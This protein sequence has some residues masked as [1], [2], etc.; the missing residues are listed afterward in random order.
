M[1]IHHPKASDPRRLQVG[2]LG[3]RRVDFVAASTTLVKPLAPWAAAFLVL[4]LVAP[5]PVAYGQPESGP[6][7]TTATR[8][9][10]GLERYLGGFP[11]GIRG[12]QPRIP[13]E[14]LRRLPLRADL[15]VGGF[16]ESIFTTVPDPLSPDYDDPLTSEPEEGS[17]VVSIRFRSVFPSLSRYL[18]VT[19]FELADLELVNAR[20]SDLRT[21]DDGN[22]YR[23]TIT[24]IEWGKPVSVSVRP[25]GV[26]MDGRINLGSRTLTRRTLAIPGGAIAQD[27]IDAIHRTL[28]ML[29]STINGSILTLILDGELDPS[30]IPAPEDFVVRSD[31]GARSTELPVMDVTVDGTQAMLLL[32]PGAIPGLGVTISYLPSP[33]HPLQDMDG[34]AASPVM[35][36]P[37]RNET[38]PRVE[39]GVP[40]AVPD[41]PVA[42]PP[43]FPPGLGLPAAWLSER[44]RQIIAGVDTSEVE[45]VD[46]PAWMLVDPDWLRLLRGLRI[47]NL[48]GNGVVDLSWLLELPN[49][50]RA[51]LSDNEIV[52]L[53][54][55]S[56]LTDM[57]CLDLANNRITDLA[58]LA[59]LTA[60]RCLDVSGNRIVDVAPLSGL[61]GLEVL[62]L[63]RNA[64]SDITPLA[65]LT[66]L[67]T[68]SMSGNR[69]SDVGLLGELTSLRRLDLSGNQLVDLSPLGDL[70]G[71][72]WLRLSRNPIADLSPVGRLTALRGLW[73]GST[74]T[75]GDAELGRMT[76]PVS[77]RP[78]RRVVGGTEAR[79]RLIERPEASLHME[80]ET[81]VVVR[82][83]DAP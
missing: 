70:T 29:N 9:D 36:M 37:V 17:F 43:P 52:D 47:L 25:N 23:V 13:P 56:D 31:S 48:P 6:T 1:R 16:P 50:V 63:D 59:T 71:L 69:L 38:P 65:H 30:S 51:D 15:A 4:A 28:S 68:L 75:E 18:R 34:N 44:I 66:S 35:D 76:H 26:S 46:L 8:P 64:I 41:I 45:R 54:P 39:S 82:S 3:S 12:V 73:L 2:I 81:P 78:Q 58:A 61:V 22:G 60:L 42:I 5:S 19:G 40:V 53:S 74:A 83:A 57:E 11:L 55:L 24:P 79:T 80:F 14:I 32:V 27:R 33:M 7:S 77:A 62:R 10:D 21:Y 67:V 20:A 49:L 72:K